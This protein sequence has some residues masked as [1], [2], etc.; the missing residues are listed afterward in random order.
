MES[1]L[2][3]NET[4]GGPGTIVEID[5]MKL[6]KRKF[7]KGRRIEGQWVFGAVQRNSRPLKCMMI[8]VPDRSE[9]TLRPL[10]EQNILPGTTIISDCWRSYA[11]L[12]QSADYTHQT[13]NHSIQFK[14]PEN[15]AHTN[16]IEGFWNYVRRSLPKYGT[17]ENHYDGYLAEIIF[18]KKWKDGDIFLKFLNEVGMIHYV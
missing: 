3:M 16:H 11:F 14:N 15:G 9:E 8:T 2:N 17:T 4:I 7:N 1:L 10:I 6:G 13:V 18:R 5:E 12:S